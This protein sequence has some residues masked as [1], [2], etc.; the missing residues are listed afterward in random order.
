MCI[1]KIAISNYKGG[2]SKTQTCY[3]LA[4]WLAMQGKKVLVIDADP[5]ANITDLLL[6]GRQPHGRSLPDILISRSPIMPEDI[7]S[8][9]FSRGRHI[10]FV[11]SNSDLGRIEG[12]I[13]T[14]IPKEYIMADKVSKVSESYDYILFDTAPSAELL[15]ISTLFTV[16][17][18]I[19]PTTLE[20][21]SVAGAEQ[22]MEMIQILKDDPRMNPNINLMGI[23]VT[24]YKR[25]LSTLLHGDTLKGKY[26]EY[27]VST[28]IRESTRVQQ[29]SNRR[30]TILE[31]DPE[32]N[33]AKDYDKAFKE[34][35]ANI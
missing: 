33:S 25:T 30:L 19:I 13:V 15:G 35:F 34:L 26:E 10:D 21:Y 4:Y 29:A 27:L 24:K 6:D 32:C 17:G 5:Q 20:R 1:M 12:R 31:Y 2:V 28:Y 7:T 8:R 14:K 11:I 22:M 23:L 9:I 3:E 18:V 16:D